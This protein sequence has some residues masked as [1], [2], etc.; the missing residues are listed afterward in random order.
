[1]KKNLGIFI[2]VLCLISLVFTTNYILA[3]DPSLVEGSVIASTHTPTLIVGVNQRRINIRIINYDL[4]YDVFISSIGFS[5]ADRYNHKLIEKNLGTWGDSG[6]DCP[7]SS[8]WVLAVSGTPRIY[9]E[10]KD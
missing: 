4:D 3:R 5:W 8:Y 1:M 2:A 10:E 7:K 6:Y 9:Y